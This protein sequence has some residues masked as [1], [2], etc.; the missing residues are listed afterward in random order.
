M[1]GIVSILLQRSRF[2]TP[3][4]RMP[5][6][7]SIRLRMETR[8]GARRRCAEV[9][10]CPVLAGWASPDVGRKNT[11]RRIRVDLRVDATML[12]ASAKVSTCQRIGFL[13]PI[14][15]ACRGRPG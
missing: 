9:G 7:K 11:F 5:D 3:P 10:A 12:P 15:A 8:P 1:S 2:H 13:S 6:E 4:Y 14:P